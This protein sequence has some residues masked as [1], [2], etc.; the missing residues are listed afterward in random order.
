MKIE[1]NVTENE[2]ILIRKLLESNKDLESFL[3]CKIE[4]VL[5]Q[6]VKEAPKKSLLD[7]I[8]EKQL[9]Q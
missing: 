7:V 9:N 8:K 2:I 5:K 6:I 3:I 4:P 1:I